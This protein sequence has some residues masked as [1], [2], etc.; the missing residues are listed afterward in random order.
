MLQAGTLRDGES[1]E[2]RDGE[3]RGHPPV[4]LG[5]EGGFRALGAVVGGGILPGIKRHGGSTSG[6][7]P[8][9]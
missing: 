7:G 2:S 6:M 9:R 5:D 3:T 4:D 1:E 8:E